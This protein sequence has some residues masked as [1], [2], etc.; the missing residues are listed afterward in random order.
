MVPPLSPVHRR[1]GG[2]EHKPEGRYITVSVF[3]GRKET[4][5]VFQTSAWRSRSTVLSGSGRSFSTPEFLDVLLLRSAGRGSCQGRTGRRSSPVV[6][7]HDQRLSGTH[8]AGN[9]M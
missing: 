6:I 7:E 9:A 5:N 1:G 2:L 4:L 3:F 8:F